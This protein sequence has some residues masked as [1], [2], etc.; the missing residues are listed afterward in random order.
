MGLNNFL[1]ELLSDLHY[2]L[3]NYRTTNQLLCLAARFYRPD[4]TWIDFSE[5]RDSRCYFQY[6]NKTE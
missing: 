1:D 5:E 4:K 3:L 6:S 2:I